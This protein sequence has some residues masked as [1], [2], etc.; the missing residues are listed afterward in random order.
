MTNKEKYP[1]VDDAM[2]AFKEHKEKYGCNCISE[3]CK[4]NKKA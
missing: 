2:K 1:N 4:K 3:L